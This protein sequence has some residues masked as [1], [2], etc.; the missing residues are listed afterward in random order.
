MAK[1]AR[2]A[3]TP[4]RR[5]ILLHFFAYLFKGNSLPEGVSNEEPTH[6]TNDNIEELWSHIAKEDQ[7]YYIDGRYVDV[8]YGPGSKQ[9]PTTPGNQPAGTEGDPAVSHT[10]PRTR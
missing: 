3:D 5:I 8:L 6:L 7:E 2:R 4:P 10:K 1:A 9:V